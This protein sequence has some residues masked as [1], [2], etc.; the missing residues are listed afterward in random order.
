LERLHFDASVGENLAR[1]YLEEQF[2]RG[3]ANL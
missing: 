3:G 2:G 1:T